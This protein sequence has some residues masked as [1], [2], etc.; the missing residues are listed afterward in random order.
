M[1]IVLNFQDK[2][3][4]L[5]KHFERQGQSV[6]KFFG[7]SHPTILNY[8]RGTLP[9]FPMRDV[10]VERAGGFITHEDF[11]IGYTMPEPKPVKEKVEKRKG[12]LYAN[13]TQ[14]I[15]LLK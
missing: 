7:V 6:D 10:I 13:I 14:R 11:L 15:I 9:S 12:F 4:A 5:Q 1:S 2:V 3:A 8:L